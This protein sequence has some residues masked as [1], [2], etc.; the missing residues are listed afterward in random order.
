MSPHRLAV[1][2]I[3]LG[4]NAWCFA[5]DPVFSGPQP[6]EELVPFQVVAVYGEKAGTEF[7]P[8]EMAGGK[9]T[10]LVFVHKL[11]RP[12][13]ASGAWTF[14]LRKE[15]ARCRGRCGVVR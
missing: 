1:L 13:I 15:S 4:C 14:K 6:G 9:P 11:T 8:I 7:D 5:D 10:L 2:L 3:L 12:G